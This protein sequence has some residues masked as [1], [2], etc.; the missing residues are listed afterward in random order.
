MPYYDVTTPLAESQHCENEAEV[1]E[2]IR[3]YMESADDADLANVTVIQ[4]P[5]MNAVETGAERPASDFW[6]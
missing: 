3:Q 6:P 2:T 5:G 1:R 4:V